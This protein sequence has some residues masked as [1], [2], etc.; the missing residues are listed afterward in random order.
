[1]ITTNNAIVTD[2]MIRQFKEEGYFIIEKALAEEQIEAMRG[3]LGGFMDAIHQK[4]DEEGTDS[5]GITHRNKRYFIPHTYNRSQIM[6]D[7]IFGPIMQE[8]CRATLGDN[9]N[10]F[11]DQWV[12]KSAE[13]GMSFSWHQDS[14]YIGFDHNP[15]L[16]CWTPLDDVNEENGTVYL[17]PYSHIG[18]KT[19]VTHIWDEVTNDMIG[20]FGDDPGIP[21]IVPAGSIAC[22]SSVCFHRSGVNTSPNMRRVMLTQYSAD[23]IID[24]LTKKPQI[25]A[26]PF[27]KDGEVI[28]ECYP[29]KDPHDIG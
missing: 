4:M 26:I 20:Y 7:F 12:V 22:F 13:K 5:L 18:V 23:R 2:D 28:N 16:T 1:M 14:G 15:Y 19:R 24:P 10:F 17:L 11:L 6:H 21:V 9:V 3:E 8:I 27:I 25:S 29:I